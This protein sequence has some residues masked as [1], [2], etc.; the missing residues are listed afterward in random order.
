MS[1]VGKIEKP[2]ETT[3]AVSVPV[4]IPL[5]TKMLD[6]IKAIDEEF[7]KIQT[8]LNGQLQLMLECYTEALEL[9][10]NQYW[11]LSED[12]KSILIHEKIAA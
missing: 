5:S 3:Q 12:K 7:Q 1:K 9:T 4:S 10:P 8:Q 11:T 6:R 2:E